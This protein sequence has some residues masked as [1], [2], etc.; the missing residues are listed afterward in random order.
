MTSAPQAKTLEGFLFPATYHLPRHPAANELA[1][2]MT[3][4]FREEWSQIMHQVRTKP[5]KRWDARCFRPITVASLV[6]RRNAEARRTAAGCGCLR[7]TA[8]KR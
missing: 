7:E 6:E 8:E 1:A 2:Q 4:K 3:Q 5:D